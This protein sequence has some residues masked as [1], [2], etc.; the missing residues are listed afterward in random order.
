ME[1]PENKQQKKRS[2]GP[3]R[4][5][6]G[7]LIFII[8]VW[9]GFFWMTMCL[10]VQ[11]YTSEHTNAGTIGDSFGVLNALISSLA[12]LAL[13]VA[14]YL[15]REELK[16]TR[17][18]R[19]DVKQ[20]LDEQIKT[21]DC[22]A[23]ESRMSIFNDTFFK[24]LDMFVEARKQVAYGKTKTPSKGMAAFRSAVS[25]AKNESAEV[26]MKRLY[27]TAKFDLYIQMLDALIQYAES[28]PTI[29][30]NPNG[31]KSVVL[32]YMN[33]LETQISADELVIV[34][35]CVTDGPYFGEDWTKGSPKEYNAIK[36]FLETREIM[37]L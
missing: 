20:T 10:D 25:E 4:L 23:W 18:Q 9:V 11:S 12:L 7:T 13:F 24:M 5:A 30:Q 8:L 33:I 1:E 3:L 27:L 29:E 15:Q 14:I 17:L 16:E 19:D 35:Y 32:P 26:V 28:A 37:K 36:K 21:A 22:Q 31:Y 34:Q 2:N 6:I